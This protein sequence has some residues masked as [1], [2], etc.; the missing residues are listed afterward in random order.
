M[1][2]NEK[3][4]TVW[5]R[6]KE[7]YQ[8]EVTT[9]YPED[10][11]SLADEPPGLGEGNGASASRFLAA[12]IGHCLAASL[13]FCLEKSRVMLDGSVNAEVKLTTRRNERGRWRIE[14]ADVKIHI[15]ALDETQKKAFERCSNLYEDFC[16]V[17]ASVRQGI[18]VDVEL[19]PA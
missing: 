1:S 13:L 5:L 9:D 16:I 14:R 3:Q 17:T 11:S 18:E 12:G 8:F 4:T 6:Q 7:H 2:E 19:V 10:W 15:P